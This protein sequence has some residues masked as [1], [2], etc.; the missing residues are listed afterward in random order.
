MQ[1]I[2]TFFS[3]YWVHMVVIALMVASAKGVVGFLDTRGLD[4]VKSELEKLRAQ[5]HANPIAGQ[6]AA[7]DAL[8]N[9][10]QDFLPEVIHELDDTIKAEIQLGKISSLD[11]NALGASL[12]A[13]AR[14]EAEAGVM[15]YMQASGEKDGE[16]LAAIVAKK[17]FMKQSALQKGLIVP[18]N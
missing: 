7:S 14:A 4:L 8:V 1:F 10:L 18:H 15:N 5:L 11:W 16:V 13:K 17:F 12:W 2:Q 9:I 6:L 3:N